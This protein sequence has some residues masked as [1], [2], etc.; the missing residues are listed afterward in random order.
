MA[1][2]VWLPLDGSARNIGISGND[3]IVMGTGITY[4]AGKIGQAATF[5]NNCNSCIHMPGLRLQEGTFAA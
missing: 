4:T 5:P 3:G 1:L 2:K